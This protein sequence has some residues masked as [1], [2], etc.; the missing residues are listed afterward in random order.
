VLS[1]LTSFTLI[2]I[3]WHGNH[4]AFQYLRRLDGRLTYLMFLQLLCIA[5]IP[6]PSAVVG[7]DVSDS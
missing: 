7:E 2:A 5:F 4:R 3:F 6:F 1:F